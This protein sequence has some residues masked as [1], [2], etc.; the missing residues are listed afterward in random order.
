MCTGWLHESEYLAAWTKLDITFI[1]RRGV[2]AVILPGLPTVTRGLT[3]L[4]KFNRNRR[5]STCI[6][7]NHPQMTCTTCLR[8]NSAWA[9][10]AARH[11]MSNN[12]FIACHCS[13]QMVDMPAT[14]QQLLTDE[15][16]RTCLTKNV[17]TTSCTFL[18]NLSH[19]TRSN[20]ASLSNGW[21]QQCFVC[22]VPVAD[23]DR[24]LWANLHFNVDHV[25]LPK[26]IPNGRG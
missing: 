7:P 12:F 18:L 25:A 6:T 4:F 16:V 2:C 23:F 3:R 22:Y 19:V 24:S 10:L 26:C 1:H 14:L 8:W 13:S 9:I 21:Q 20:E 15:K 17:Q 11:S 5:Y